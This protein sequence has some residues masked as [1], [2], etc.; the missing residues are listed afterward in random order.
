M[1]LGS[2]F[3]SAIAMAMRLHSTQVRKGNGSPYIGHLLAVTSLVVENG[4]TEDEAIAAILHDAVED[5]GGHS[6][7]H[8]IRSEFG[9]KVANVVAECT[10]TFEAQK[11]PWRKRKEDY[12]A[13]IPSKSASARLVSIADTIHNAQS[14]LNDF[15]ATGHEL[16]ERFNGGRNGTLWYYRTLAEAFEKTGPQQLAMQLRSLIGQ[17]DDTLARD[18]FRP[19]E[20][21]DVEMRTGNTRPCNR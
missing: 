11:S 12:I 17:L 5:Q 3:E 18:A 8:E 16:W 19:D 1:I 14:L 6:A 4:G 9:N 10:D 7:L 2:R 13:T 15:S 21:T 20:R